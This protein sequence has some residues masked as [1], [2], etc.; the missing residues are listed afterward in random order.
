MA[1]SYPLPKFYFKVDWGGTEIGFTEISGLD[2]ETEAIEYRAGNSSIFSK[3]K[4]PGMQKYSNITMKRGT[5][6]SNPEFYDWWKETVKFQEG[7]SLGSVY[8]K[9]I[10]ISLLDEEGKD[11][12]IWKVLNAWPIKVQSTD[13]KSDANDIAIESIEIVHEGLT[14]EFK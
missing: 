2:V 6:K 14:I 12:V 7:G 4:Q 3:T 13:L 11:I 9:S 8:R 1:E 5:F 10:T